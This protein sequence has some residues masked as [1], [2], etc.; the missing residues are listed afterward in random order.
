MALN[1][2]VKFI[3][4]IKENSNFRNTLYS[5]D[6]PTDLENHIKCLGYN[7]N[8]DESE[9]AY[10]KLLLACQSED[11]AYTITEVFNMYRMLLGMHPLKL[12]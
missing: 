5:C 7:F 10:R 11:D 8:Y 2:A 6:S 9:D 3:D 1:D 12:N 4:K